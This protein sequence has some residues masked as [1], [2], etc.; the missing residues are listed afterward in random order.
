MQ[1][2]SS[3]GI[4]LACL[5]MNLG[6]CVFNSL[7]LLSTAGIITIIGFQCLWISTFQFQWITVSCVSCFTE[8]NAEVVFDTDFIW[9]GGAM[10]PV[11]RLA[12]TTHTQENP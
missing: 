11:L 1:S 5:N 8:K 12:G 7:L 10:R 3:P 6:R 2:A 9:K 4:L